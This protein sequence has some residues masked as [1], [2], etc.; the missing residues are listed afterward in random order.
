M[1]RKTLTIKIPL[2]FEISNLSPLPLYREVML[3]NCTKSGISN[4]SLIL[5]YIN[6][7]DFFRSFPIILGLNGS[8]I[9]P[10]GSLD[11]FPVNAF[12]TL[13]KSVIDQCLIFTSLTN[14]N[15]SSNK[16]SF[17]LFSSLRSSLIGLCL[18]RCL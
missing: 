4:F 15:L 11:L 5:L 7:K 16:H 12:N 1:L 2:S 13:S 17:Q 10:W 6:N 14:S 8:L 9:R 3:A 18:R